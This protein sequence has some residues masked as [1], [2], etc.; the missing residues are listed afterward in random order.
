M[1]LLGQYTKERNKA[2]TDWDD[3]QRRIG[4]LPELEKPESSGTPFPELEP[5][6][7]DLVPDDPE[8]GDEGGDELERLR[9]LRL[10]QLKAS[11]TRHSTVAEICHADFV[12]E[13]NEAGEGIG[14]VVF[15]HRERHYQSSYMLVLLEQLARKFPA[16]KFVRI[17]STECIPGYPDA[18][19]PTLLFYRDDDLKAQAVGPAAFGGSSYGVDGARRAPDAPRHRLPTAHAPCILPWPCT[20]AVPLLC[21]SLHPR[22]PETGHVRAASSPAPVRHA[23]DVEWEIAQAGLIR[24]ELPKNPHPKGVLR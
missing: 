20:Q 7:S 16:L 17:G 11:D 5:A 18:N 19:L 14:V 13:V 8:A 2:E 10:Q 4:N 23:A 12:S 9:A 22:T 15:L 21:G 24:T 6:A 1:S 3:A